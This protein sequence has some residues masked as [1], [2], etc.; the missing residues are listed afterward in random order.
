M[1][2]YD[3]AKKSEALISVA[4][5]IVSCDNKEYDDYVRYCDDNGLEP[6]DITG[7]EQSQHV[8]AQALIGLGLEFPTE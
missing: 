8:Y 7:A 6:S 3:E 1:S 2:L 4:E 5:Y